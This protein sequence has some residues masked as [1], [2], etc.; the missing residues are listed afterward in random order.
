MGNKQQL[1]LNNENLQKI[2]SE[3]EGMPSGGVELKIA[4][5]DGVLIGTLAKDEDGFYKMQPV[6][7]PWAEIDA[8][9]G[10]IQQAIH[11]LTNKYI[12]GVAG[13]S[14]WEVHGYAD[15]QVGD[16]VGYITSNDESTYPDGG[17]KDGYWYERYKSPITCAAGSLVLASEPSSFEAVHNLD[18]LPRLVIFST[19]ENSKSG[20]G[21]VYADSIIFD[22]K[23][24]GF[25]HNYVHGRVA[26]D[27]DS[28]IAYSDSELKC[29]DV[30]FG[31][32]SVYGY[33][34]FSTGQST[35]RINVYLKA[36]I[37]YKWV[38]IA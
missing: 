21:K 38:A 30:K 8:Q 31:P 4:T 36:G 27:E 32:E 15:E 24:E 13:G 3:L 16:F 28:G 37:E 33:L 6:E 1:Q 35:G 11:V 25:H 9:E 19:D 18:T 7:D 10:L 20:T 22:M 17:V 34:R 14:I 26:D 5:Q 23:K 2:L 29:D 12:A